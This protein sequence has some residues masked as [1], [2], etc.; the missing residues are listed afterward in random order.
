MININKLK[1]EWVSAEDKTDYK[2]KVVMNINES[3]QQP[4][5][6]NEDTNYHHQGAIG[7]EPFDLVTFTVFK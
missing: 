2:N 1:N 6:K 3:P 7:R 5:W 4:V